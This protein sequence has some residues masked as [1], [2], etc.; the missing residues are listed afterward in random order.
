MKKPLILLSLA[1]SLAFGQASAQTPPPVPPVADAARIQTSV[2]TSST[3]AIDLQFPLYGGCTDLQVWVNNGLLDTSLWTCVSKSGTPISIITQPITDGQIQFSPALTS[4]TVI[5]EGDW[6]PRR[7]SQPTSPGV[8]R[9][10][11]NQ[12]V[13]NIISSQR[14][15]YDAVTRSLR[16]PPGETL[17]AIPLSVDR[18]NK[19]LGFDDNG[20]PVAFAGQTVATAAQVGFIAI[21][22]GA[23]TRTVQDKIR[24]TLS[25]TDFG[26]VADNSTD[27]TTAFARAVA[28]AQAQAK[29]LYINGGPGAVYLTDMIDYGSPGSNSPSIICEPGTTLRKRTADG[30]PVVRI[31]SQTGAKY[32][33]PIGQFLSGCTIDGNGK[34][35]DG[36]DTYDLV[37]TT[38]NS[39]VVTNAV[40]GWRNFGGIELTFNSLLA[41]ANQIG[42]KA[43][44]Y[45]SVVG[46]VPNIINLNSPILV[47][48]TFAGLYYQGG[49]QLFVTNFEIE[50]N[51][52]T[53]DSARGGAY[54]EGVTD[55]VGAIFNGGWFESNMGGFNLW[56]NGGNNVVYNPQFINSPLATNDVKVTLGRFTLNNPI[57]VASKTA[58]INSTTTASGNSIIDP[59]CAN[60]VYDASKTR[61]QQ[62]Q[63]TNNVTITA[64]ATAATLTIADGKTATVSNT[65]TFAGTD[66]STLNVGAGGTLGSRAFD[67]T[68]YLPL[69]GGTMSGDVA[70]GGHNIS[71]GGTATFSTFAGALTGNSST[72]SAW[73]TARNIAGNSVDGSANVPFSNKFIAQGTTDTGLSGAQFLGALGT[74]IV[75]NTTTTGVLS[76]A[77]AADLPALTST[78]SSNGSVTLPGG[79]II[80]WGQCDTSGTAP[81]SCSV[82]FAA[83]FPTNAWQIIAAPKNGSG[84]AQASATVTTSGATLYSTPT[85]ATVSYIAIGN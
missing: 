66:G 54:I 6:R 18:K 25:A 76:I 19:I 15:Q 68:G 3:S 14:E 49:N 2:I 64:P 65:L 28:A 50:G 70:M 67:S 57:C 5:I 46:G 8:T 36:V 13:S 39:A 35:G 45:A 23:V 75:K 82:T 31:G 38:V 73:Q 78:A 34:G 32:T 81:G 74:G 48:N 72:A 24:E 30:N 41:Q 60:M 4:G 62:G 17:T 20:N 58:N 55:G 51:G 1:L 52:T 44:S 9:R 7:V 27:N 26:A 85:T 40:T 84:V 21:G 59:Q 22:T 42:F 80:K 47:D 83:A 11:L 63:S 33:G 16:S 71:G 43:E 37:R 29:P 77:T 10:E 69:A 53:G 12:T 79:I 56:F 61:V